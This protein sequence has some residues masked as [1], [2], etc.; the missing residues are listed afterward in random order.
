MSLC[1]ERSWPLDGSLEPHPVDE[2]KLYYDAVGGRNEKNMI[3]GLGST[4]NVFYEPSSRC[5]S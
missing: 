5:G 3:Y 1:A 4:Q 2:N